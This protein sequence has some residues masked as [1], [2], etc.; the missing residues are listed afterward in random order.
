LPRLIALPAL[1]YGRS[2]QPDLLAVGAF[3][4]QIAVQAPGV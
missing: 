2:P 4:M 3:I 1:P